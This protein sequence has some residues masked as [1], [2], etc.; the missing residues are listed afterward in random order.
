MSDR[1]RVVVVSSDVG[2]RAH[3]RLT[4]GDDRFETLEAEDASTGARL[5]AEHDPAVLVLDLALPDGGALALARGVRSR[6]EMAGL[7]TLALVPRGG[8]LPE[9]AVGVDAS[10]LVPS[11]SFALLRKVDGLLGA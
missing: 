4:L 5:V 11:T 2:T 9:D 10:L 7:R 6:P 8:S 1:A 3:V